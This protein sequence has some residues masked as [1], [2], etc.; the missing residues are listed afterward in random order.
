MHILDRPRGKEYEKEF[1]KVIEDNF[2]D[3][4][5]GSPFVLTDLGTMMWK[6]LDELQIVVHGFYGAHKTNYTII[7]DNK[8]KV[9]KL[10]VQ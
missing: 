7:L 1:L 3:S 8:F 10:L 9:K 5:R 4:L 2:F 6:D